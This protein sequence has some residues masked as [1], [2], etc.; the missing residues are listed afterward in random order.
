MHKHLNVKYK[1]YIRL[2]LLFFDICPIQT[3]DI[4][5]NGYNL[6][7]IYPKGEKT[8]I[9]NCKC[10]TNWK[11]IFLE[12]KVLLIILFYTYAA[13]L[14]LEWI[15]VIWV[16]Q[17]IHSVDAALYAYTYTTYNILY[18]YTPCIIRSYKVSS[19][20]KKFFIRNFIKWMQKMFSKISHSFLRFTWRFSPRTIIGVRGLL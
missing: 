13:A 9:T 3:F 12:Y 7:K 2:C 4:R 16:F 5:I 14:Q 6:T 17:D 15:S 18:V 19:I 11:H 10:D 8:K 1:V 20:I